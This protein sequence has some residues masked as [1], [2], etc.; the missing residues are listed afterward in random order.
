MEV[1]AG[2]R[3]M[4]NN[5]RTML[6][7]GSTFSKRDADLHLTLSLILSWLKF[8]E[9]P[10]IT[11]LPFSPLFFIYLITPTPFLLEET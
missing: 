1:E 9:T 7:L 11:Y 10:L 4:V 5:V 8:K 6:N 3:R 2:I